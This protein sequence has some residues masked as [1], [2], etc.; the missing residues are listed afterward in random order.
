MEDATDGVNYEI[1]RACG[2]LTVRIPPVKSKVYYFP[3]GHAEHASFPPSITGCPPVVLCRLDSVCFCANR[4]TD[5]VF[6][7]FTM[8]PISSSLGFSSG[9]E[10]DAADCGLAVVSYSKVLTQSDANNGGG[11]SVPRACAD[12]IFP[13][14]NFDADPPVQTI[15]V[16]DVHG[17]TWAFR[18]I[19]RGTPR[20]HLLTT[21]WS[22]FVNN[23]KLVAGDSIVF[24]RAASGAIFV[25]VRRTTWGSSCGEV[26]LKWNPQ[27]KDCQRMLEEAESSSST[28]PQGFWRRKGRVT[29]TTVEEA[30][31]R[32]TDNRSFEVVYYPRAGAPEFCVG[33]E[34]V[35]EAMKLSWAAGMKVRIPLETEDSSKTS[36]CTGTIAAVSVAD[37]VTWPNSPWKILQV[38]WDEPESL[39][40][41]KRVSPWE[42]EM[43]S[44][45]PQIALPQLSF[46]KKKS[47]FLESPDPAAAETDGVS[48]SY[49]P[50]AAL[51]P[52]MSCLIPPLINYNSFPPSGMQGARHDSVFPSTLHDFSTLIKTHHRSFSDSHF[53]RSSST[54][55]NWNY[56]SADRTSSTCR[57]SQSEWSSPESS[58]PVQNLE[59]DHRGERQ[60][61]SLPKGSGGCFLQLFG[62]TIWT[63][64]NIETNRMPYAGVPA[65][66]TKQVAE[67]T[68]LSN[69]GW[70]DQQPLEADQLHHI[71]TED[72]QDEFSSTNGCRVCKVYKKEEGDSPGR[73][74]D[75]STFCS[76]EQLYK[77]LSLMFDIDEPQLCKRLFYRESTGSLR[78]PGEQPFRDFAKMVRRLM[79]I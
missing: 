76:Y 6:A 46:Q 14:L 28:L 24:I 62:K 68:E 44:T 15:N 36:W 5:E 4:E 34:L 71:G 57:F 74:L 75:L 21:G 41:V 31:A 9:S 51:D 72:V 26:T 79:I 30:A 49:S 23:K 45:M 66:I 65:A 10:V 7:I 3:Q 64:Q 55:P 29:A 56:G 59:I 39:P 11:F 38:T 22:K 67:Y 42:V 60:S 16:R 19:Y 25:G 20:R 17:T 13:P 61:R 12:S 69:H 52:A 70:S 48:T 58:S 27:F 2:G 37:P 50:M 8:T 43:V 54:F 40:N 35:D 77:K 1:W 53:G 73:A 47:R 63:E 32:A 18:H 78:Q 33:A